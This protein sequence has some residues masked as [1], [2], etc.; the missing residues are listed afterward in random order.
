VAEMLLQS[1]ETA[2]SESR[3]LETLVIISLLPS[4]PKAWQ[5][6]SVKGL[7]ARGGF[8]VDIEWRDGMLTHYRIASSEPR[9]VLIRINGQVQSARSV[10]Q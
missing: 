2:N 4:L 3:N 8:I 7:R 10:K 1:H 6:G 5:N 9:E